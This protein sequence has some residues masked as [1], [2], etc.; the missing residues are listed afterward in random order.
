MICCIGIWQ[1]NQSSHCTVGT[2]WIS[3][4]LFDLVSDIGHLRE[5]IHVEPAIIFFGEMTSNWQNSLPLELWRPLRMNKV[6]ST[7]EVG[8][9]L[10]RHVLWKHVQW[11]NRH[12]LEIEHPQFCLLFGSSIH[13]YCVMRLLLPMA[14]RSFFIAPIRGSQV[15]LVSAALFDIVISIKVRMGCANCEWRIL[16]GLFGSACLGIVPMWHSVS[17][18]GP[19]YHRDRSHS[20][21]M[22]VGLFAKCLHEDCQGPNQCFLSRPNISTGKINCFYRLVWAR[23][24]T[25]TS[26]AILD[27]WNFLSYRFT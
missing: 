12:V 9:N 25:I 23:L 21:L 16:V 13:F 1:S 18:N 19:W 15:V 27:L 26:S 3:E 7:S 17:S 8:A 22:Q 10:M 14:S 4:K 5:V 20:N 24:K 11:I 2:L 6:T